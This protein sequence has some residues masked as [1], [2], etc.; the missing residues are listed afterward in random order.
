MQMKRACVSG[1]TLVEL[2]VVLA[3]MAIIATFS[4]PSFFAW[5]MRDQ[6]DARARSLFATLSLARAEALRRGRAR[7]VMQGRRRAPLPCIG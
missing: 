2:C 4:A 3:V 6:V 5:Q 7:H 1:F